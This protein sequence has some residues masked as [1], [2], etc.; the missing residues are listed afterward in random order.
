MQSEHGVRSTPLPS[1]N[2][3]F[4][5]SFIGRRRGSNVS[6][7]REMRDGGIGEFFLVVLCVLVSGASLRDGRVS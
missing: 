4:G 1:G 2:T 5:T 6:D 7:C 3:G